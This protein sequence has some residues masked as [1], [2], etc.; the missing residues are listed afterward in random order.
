MSW[1]VGN[2][3]TILMW[4]WEGQVRVVQHT[5]SVHF[6][7]RES[8]HAVEWSLTNTT[9]SR[10]WWKGVTRFCQPVLQWVDDGMDGGP[11]K[12][13]EVGFWYYY[14]TNQSMVIKS[15]QLVRNNKIISTVSQSS[16]RTPDGKPLPFNH[17][18]KKRRLLKKGCYPIDFYDP[19]WKGKTKQPLN[20]NDDRNKENRQ[21]DRTTGE[22]LLEEIMIFN[23]SYK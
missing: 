4:G 15:Y 18:M 5:L 7:Q 11:R 13:G 2:K 21:R 1:M 20:P 19:F 17:T 23:P 12:W 6:V 22:I 14:R 9:T 16:K 10:Q 8:T 3:G